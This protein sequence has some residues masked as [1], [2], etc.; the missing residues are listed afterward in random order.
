M[1]EKCLL[2]RHN[3]ETIESL[4]YRHPWFQQARI[5][6]ILEGRRKLKVYFLENLKEYMRCGLYEDGDQTSNDVGESIH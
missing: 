5:L 6:T 3:I 1:Q 4:F 2:A